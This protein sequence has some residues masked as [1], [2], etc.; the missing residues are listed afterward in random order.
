MSEDQYGQ[1]MHTDSLRNAKEYE[2]HDLLRL[3]ALP[4]ADDMP[5]WLPG[6]FADAPFA[7]VRRAQA[8][9]GSVAVGFRGHARQQRYGTFVA[10]EDI[11]SAS[12]P[13]QLLHRHAGPGRWTLAPFSAL[14]VIVESGCL[15]SLVW[16]PTG[17]V[18]FELATARPTAT[19]TSDL[20]LLIRTPSPLVREH[21]RTLRAR[22][23][24]VERNMGVRIDA[25]LETPAG[26]VALSEW[27][28]DKARVLA[29]SACGPS[30]IADPW[31]SAGSLGEA[32]G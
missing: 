27:A 32:N 10:H 17:S 7:V 12:P 23:G 8:P 29:R 9:R 4:L 24:V 28:E 2:A 14:R 1:R 11:E 6:A 18:G 25:Q 16:G 30:L 20:D 5:A 19:D 15:G 13:E 22:L 26:G 3:H 31:A 21:A